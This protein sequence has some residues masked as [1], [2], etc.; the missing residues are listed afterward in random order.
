MAHCHKRS[1]LVLKR[2]LKVAAVCPTYRE[3]LDL[4]EG[5]WISCRESPGFSPGISS[6]KDQIAMKYLLGTAIGIKNAGL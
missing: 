4:Q 1:N 2:G 6:E 5:K 3:E